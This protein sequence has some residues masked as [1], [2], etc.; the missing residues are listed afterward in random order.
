MAVC[1]YPLPLL[2][3]EH[4]RGSTAISNPNSVYSTCSPSLK[5]TLE[6][7]LLYQPTGNPHLDRHPTFTLAITLTLHLTLNLTI[8]CSRQSTGHLYLC[9]LSKPPHISP[10]PYV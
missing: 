6:L 10:C 2:R 1:I 3:H 9:L 5:P 8:M 7:S 4:G